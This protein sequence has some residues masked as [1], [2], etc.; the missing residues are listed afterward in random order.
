MVVQGVSVG[1]CMR[2]TVVLRSGFSDTARATVSQG[3]AHPQR[4]PLH[5]CGPVQ[6]FGL[7]E[8]AANR[9]LHALPDMLCHLQCLQRN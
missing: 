3:G 5:A 7:L 2:H 4:L 8:M 9:K 1:Q 6:P